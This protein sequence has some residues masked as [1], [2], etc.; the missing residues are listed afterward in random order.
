MISKPNNIIP[1]NKSVIEA[2]NNLQ[3]LPHRSLEPSYFQEQ[4]DFERQIQG[5]TFTIDTNNSQN[6]QGLTNTATGMR[7]KFYESNVVLDEVRKHFE[8]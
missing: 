1:T 7:I 4:N 3:E 6:Q 5:Q 8:E 2:M